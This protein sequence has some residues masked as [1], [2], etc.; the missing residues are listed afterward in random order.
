MATIPRDVEGCT[1]GHLAS[2]E[3]SRSYD[4]RKPKTREQCSLKSHNPEKNLGY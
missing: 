3:P 4:E 2:Y 1:G